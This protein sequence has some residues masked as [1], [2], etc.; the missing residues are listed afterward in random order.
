MAISRM[1]P[2]KFLAH[3]TRDLVPVRPT[4]IVPY[5]EGH[6]T[7]ESRLNRNATAYPQPTQSRL[8]AKYDYEPITLPSVAKLRQNNKHPMLRTSKPGLT[9]SSSLVK[10]DAAAVVKEICQLSFPAKVLKELPIE[11]LLNRLYLINNVSWAQV[12]KDKALLAEAGMS[13]FTEE[14]LAQV[15][16]KSQKY[17][18]HIKECV[19][20]KTRAYMVEH[21]FDEANICDAD[22]ESNVESLLLTSQ[23]DSNAK[24]LGRDTLLPSS[25]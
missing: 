12:R 25:E 19:K 1:L 5:D 21:G 3:A 14:N 8:A 17:A 13:T 7:R 20:D 23:I 2:T 6:V 16:D 18:D 9:F 10:K 24:P 15:Y 4:E 11:K 22:I